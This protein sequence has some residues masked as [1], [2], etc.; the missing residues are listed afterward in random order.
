M[1]GVVSRTEGRQPIAITANFLWQLWKNQI[2][3]FFTGNLKQGVHL[4]KQAV[5]EWEEFV[6]T[7]NSSIPIAANDSGMEQLQTTWIAP[8]EEGHEGEED[9]EIGGV[10]KE[11]HGDLLGQYQQEND[12]DLFEEDFGFSWGH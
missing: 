6:T 2:D 3:H 11:T 1:Q 8:E 7:T 4:A 5:Q 9:G 10:T 12:R